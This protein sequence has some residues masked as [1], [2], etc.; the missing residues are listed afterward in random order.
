LRVNIQKWADLPAHP[1]PKQVAGHL[2]VDV[3]TVRRY[4]A[5]GRLKADRVGPRLIR[6]DRD[7][8]LKL[9][10]PIGGAA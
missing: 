1:S 9:A 8:V 2:G 4:I 7:S 5:Q 10:Q 6:I 3:K